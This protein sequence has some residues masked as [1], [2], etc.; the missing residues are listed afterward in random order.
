MQNLKIKI[1]FK[2]LKQEP[3][4]TAYFWEGP[5]T[6]CTWEMQ[7]YARTQLRVKSEYPSTPLSSGRMQ[8]SVLNCR[9]IGQKIP[10]DWDWD[11]DWMA[12]S[13]ILLLNVLA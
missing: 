6:L 13:S 3:F 1:Y 12:F 11:R 9:W 8:A 2:F 7:I 5:P 10:W 4:S